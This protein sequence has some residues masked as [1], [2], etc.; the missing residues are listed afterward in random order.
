[1]LNNEDVN[2]CPDMRLVDGGLQQEECSGEFLIA[3]C[4]E[5]AALLCM[6]G[7]RHRCGR[8]DVALIP[9]GAAYQIGRAHV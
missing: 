9:R 8:G 3:V 2:L 5:G 1:M 7:V 4:V 6:G